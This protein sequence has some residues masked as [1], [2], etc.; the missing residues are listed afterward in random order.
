LDR[1]VTRAIGPEDFV[2]AV[3]VQVAIDGSAIV[4][5]CGHPAPL[6]VSADLEAGLESLWAE[7][8]RHVAGQLHD[9]IALLL[10]EH[11]RRPRPALPQPDAGRRRWADLHGRPAA[12]EP[13]S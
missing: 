12:S 4:V 11:S 13:A 6:L 5:N 2:T 9:D 10:I 1:S 8:Q 7:L 3:A